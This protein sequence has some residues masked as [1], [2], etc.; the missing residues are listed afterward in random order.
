[1]NLGIGEAVIR[2]GSAKD[3]F[4]AKIPLA[5]VRVSNRTSIIERSRERYCRF[6]D[7]VE[8]L[9]NPEGEPDGWQATAD[10]P[11]DSEVLMST[12]RNGGR[13]SMNRR[14]S[15]VHQPLLWSPP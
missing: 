4:N 5:E 1:M 7:E 6:K 8:R 9:L 10:G 11:V 14:M 15:Q 12:D 13:R 3:T 2:M